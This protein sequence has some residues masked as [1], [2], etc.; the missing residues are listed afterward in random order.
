MIASSRKGKTQTT[1][2]LKTE[3]FYYENFIKESVCN[4]KLQQ[5]RL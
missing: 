3:G 5:R 2:K 4:V 1:Q